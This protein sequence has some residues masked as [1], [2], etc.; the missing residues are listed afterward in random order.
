MVPQKASETGKC[1]RLLLVDDH[2]PW[3]RWVLSK[4]QNVTEV[5]VVGEALDGL[6][7]V[8]QSQVLQPDVILLDI[9]L[10]VLNGI[11]AAR[12]IREVSPV[13]KILFTTENR[14][15]DIVEEALRSGGSGYVLKS[16][17]ATELLTAV[18]AV[19]QGKTFLSDCLTHLVQIQP[20]VESTASPQGREAVGLS[21]RAQSIAN[22]S[23]KVRLYPDDASL[24]DGFVRSIEAALKDGNVA[25]VVATEPQREAILERLNSDGVDVE[26]AIERKLYIQLDV[27]G[28]QS[29]F[30]PDCSTRANEFAK[31]VALGEAIRIAKAS[32][33]TQKR[34][35]KIT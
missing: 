14:S 20:N 31:V 26:H 19:L 16:N 34:P 21:S 9:G 18:E 22:V 10:P 27:A 29:I 24:V 3:R 35:C 28:T 23:H 2:E 15:W 6:A 32:V 33:I 8:Q 5:Q 4:L 11:E 12:Q 13:S 25:F 1:A 17:A 7:A 30:M